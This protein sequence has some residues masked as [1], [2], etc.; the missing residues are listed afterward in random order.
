MKN[1]VG[2]KI[3][4]LRKEKGI[5]QKELAKQLCTSDK[6]VSK[7]E[8]G[9]SVPDI[10]YLK[11]IADFFGVDVGYFVNDEIFTHEADVKRSKDGLTRRIVS[12]IG[13]ISAFACMPLILCAIVRLYMPDSIPCHYDAYGNI[14]RWGSSA[15]VIAA[16]AL[17]SAMGI[18]FSLFLLFFKSKNYKG[19]RVTVDVA[20]ILLLITTFILTAVAAVIVLRQ[21]ADAV[22]VYGEPQERKLFDSM[23]SL[24]FGAIMWVCGG[25]MMAVPRNALIGVRLPATMDDDRMWNFVNV[26][27]G[28]VTV[29]ISY[30]STLLQ[31]IFNDGGIAVTLAVCICMPVVLIIT[32]V[33]GVKLARKFAL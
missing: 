17:Y 26:F 1:S 6:N 27:T 9:R 3:S 16:G 28:A 20:A 31:G 12:W 23:F 8:C 11:S 7:W 4:A 22:A 24:I 10:F 15:E 19:G 30:I 33:A 5:T 29:V 21:R 2:E 32:A 13:I 18:G 14:T 25:I